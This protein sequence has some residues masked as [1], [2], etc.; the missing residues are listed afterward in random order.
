MSSI[1]ERDRDF[2]QNPILLEFLRVQLGL[3]VYEATALV[4]IILGSEQPTIV[5]DNTGI[6]RS[7]VYGTL[8]SLM[9]KGLI[10]KIES[11]YQPNAAAVSDLATH[12]NAL[13]KEYTQ[14]INTLNTYTSGPTRLTAKIREDISDAFQENGFKVSHPRK[15]LTKDKVFSREIENTMR[16][17]ISRAYALHSRTRR[18]LP[19][20]YV[21]KRLIPAASSFIDLIGE[22][23]TSGIRV[24]ASILTDAKKIEEPILIEALME[25]APSIWNC[26]SVIVLFS[27]EV[28]SKY[29]Q[30]FSRVYEQRRESLPKIKI[31]FPGERYR[32]EISAYLI[33]IDMR[34]RELKDNLFEKEDAKDATKEKIRK[35]IVKIDDLMSQIGSI[36]GEYREVYEDIFLRIKRDLQTYESLTLNLEEKIAL[37]FRMLEN[38]EIFDVEGLLESGRNL[39]E[40]DRSVEEKGSELV[41]FEEEIYSLNSGANPYQKYGFLVN[42]FSLTVPMLR[43]QTVIDETEQKKNMANFI[44]NVLKGSDANVLFLVAKEGGGKSH[45]LNFHRGNINENQYG[46]AFAIK[47]QCRPNR[48][49]LDLYP[50]I[51]TELTKVAKEKTDE[52]LSSA[53]TEALNEGGTPRVISDLMR[54]LRNIALRISAAGYGP[55]FILIDEFE[56]SLPM[57]EQDRRKPLPFLGRKRIA[58]PQA[59]N[60]LDSL[61]QLSGIGFKK[62]ISWQLQVNSRKSRTF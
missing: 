21:N 19:S 20:D 15:D 2:L 57:S 46:K 41:N 52:R 42:P 39:K 12:A 43:P 27:P 30:E 58:T 36:P 62:N 37:A 60:Q 9:K 51:S 44:E 17:S 38:K 54:I 10:V 59:I 45:F 4:S 18:V 53:I 40:I 5:A 25:M 55:L 1:I 56:N 11:G 50:Q 22:S 61:T 8:D 23:I 33:S 49:L 24:G 3:T 34:W 13:T 7:K 31:L 26:Q 16:Y 32:E 29:V 48:D 14:F 35:Y 28:S 6:P 47:I